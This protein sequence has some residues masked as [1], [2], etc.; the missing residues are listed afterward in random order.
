VNLNR[1]YSEKEDGL[2][3]TRLVS[4]GEAGN[5]MQVTKKT[6]AST[7]QGQASIPASTPSNLKRNWFN[8][9]ETRIVRRSWKL[10]A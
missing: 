2:T 9:N 7:P 6:P 5:W 8:G 10:D 1:D 3:V 4:L